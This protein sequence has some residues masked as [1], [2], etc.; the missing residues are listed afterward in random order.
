MQYTKKTA[1]IP[2]N[3]QDIVSPGSFYL[4]ENKKRKFVYEKCIAMFMIMAVVLLPAFP[5]LAQFKEGE[6]SKKTEGSIA[7]DRVDSTLLKNIEGGVSSTLAIQATSTIPLETTTT[8]LVHATE[9]KGVGDETT[10]IPYAVN[11][12]TKE[13]VILASS[14]ALI[15]NS[16]Q[17]NITD[18]T[19]ASTS[20]GLSVDEL[21]IQIRREVEDELRAKIATGEFQDKIKNEITERIRQGCLEFEDGSYYCIKNTERAMPTST[22]AAV[23]APTVF[24]NKDSVSGNRKI[25]LKENDQVKQISDEKE[26]TLF[27]GAD[28]YGNSVVWQALVS[29]VWQIMVYDRTTASTTQL[30][31]G[32][33]N[34]MNPQIQKDVIVWQGWADNNWEIF[35]AQKSVL[36]TPSATSTNSIW[37]LK[38]ITQNTWHDMFPRISN[39]FI[40]WQVYKG[41]VWQVF[42]YNIETGITSQLSQGSEK[43]ENPRFVVL[44]E[45]RNIE[46]DVQT[47]GYDMTS[48]EELVIG[49]HEDKTP[50]KDVPQ[51]PLQENKG[52]IPSSQIVKLKNSSDEGGE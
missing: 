15:S 44:W 42:M 32:G 25:Y 39:G 17:P 13:E 8:E 19:I 2:R 50:F 48:G 27:P 47:Y 14:T 45:K 12:S 26:D 49:K 1:R 6:E 11:S 21:R 10:I 28:L 51:T 23:Q 16:N 7:L 37:A 40:T 43:S 34:N 24:V 29:N 38:R 52:V 5:T 4:Y 22:E 36:G 46:G 9:N 41:G 35:V 30:T 31:W 33:G 20:K 3:T 18:T